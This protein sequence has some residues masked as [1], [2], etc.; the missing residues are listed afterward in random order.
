VDLSYTDED[1]NFRRAVADWHLE[2]APADAPDPA[3]GDVQFGVAPKQ[4]TA[5]LLGLCAAFFRRAS[6]TVHT[7]LRQFLTDHGHQGGAGWF[8][9]A[10][11]FP[12]STTPPRETTP[13][14]G[15]RRRA[16]HRPDGSLSA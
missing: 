8:L 3:D 14:S 13:P 5:E 10:L 1:E 12:T 4:I 11:S 2:F 9:E 6:P 7:E 15:A 16:S